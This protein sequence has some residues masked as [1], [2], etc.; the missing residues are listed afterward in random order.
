MIDA[1]AACACVTLI[2][3]VVLYHGKTARSSII[4]I[5]S[6]AKYERKSFL[7]GWL[8][9]QRSDILRSR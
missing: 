1:C 9:V 2:A 6:I 5:I 4:A 7:S 3:Q 8:H